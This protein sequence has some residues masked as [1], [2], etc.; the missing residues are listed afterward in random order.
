MFESPISRSWP[1]YQ[2]LNVL[3]FL[4]PKNKISLKGDD[5]QRALIKALLQE[6]RF[7]YMQMVTELKFFIRIL[8]K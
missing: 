2:H 7:I 1:V 4:R 5:E 3:L 6:E 8:C